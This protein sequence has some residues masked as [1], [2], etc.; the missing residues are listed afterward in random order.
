M[1]PL[2]GLRI[3]EM[4]GLG[5]APFAGMLFSDM[6]AEVIRIERKRAAVGDAFDRVK[7]ANFVDRG[8]RLVALDLKKPEAVEATLEI[9]AKADALI[10]GFRPGVMERLGLGP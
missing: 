9:V 1:G 5:P 10:E 7:D 8:R 2:S 6:G 3:V 4:A